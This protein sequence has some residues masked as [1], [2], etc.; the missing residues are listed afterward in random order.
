MPSY[1]SEIVSLIKSTSVVGYVT[2]EDLTRASDLIR[3][4]TYDAF[5]P[6]FVTAVIYFVLI[7][8]VTVVANKLQ[9]KYLPNEK[10]KKEILKSVGKD[11]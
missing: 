9:T 4:R 2:V 3:S 7:Y 11:Y 5:F 6:L 10:S 8:L 1:R